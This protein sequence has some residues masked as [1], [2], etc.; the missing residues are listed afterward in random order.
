MQH[1]IVYGIR[2]YGIEV[3]RSERKR[4][5]ITVHPDLRITAK[6]PAIIKSKDIQKRLENRA[7]WIA[8]QVDF[9][10]KYHPLPSKRHYVSGETHYYLGRQ[11]RLRIRP[12]NANRVKLIGRYF[13]VE[14]SKKND[15]VIIKTMMEKWYMQHAKSLLKRRLEKYLPELIRLGA[16]EPEIHFRR[17]QKRWGS[18][19][20]NGAI[21]LNTQLVK[22]TLYG[23]DYVIVHELCH[24]LYPD[25]NNNF[26][27]LL[28][29]ILPDWEKRKSRLEKT[30]I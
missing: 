27:N 5:S 14:V 28:R 29:R 16:T 19:S 23:I 7:A 11:F 18:C 17:M 6:A 2:E 10:K 30:V 13:E 22:A 21:V 26:S 3:E 9:F 25:H 4:L 20:R 24:L 1:T 8:R 15:A 12:G